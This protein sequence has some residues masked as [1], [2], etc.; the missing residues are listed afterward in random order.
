MWPRTCAWKTRF[1]SPSRSSSVSM[2]RLFSIARTMSAICAFLALLLHNVELLV[3]L[4][5]LRRRRRDRDELRVLRFSSEG[6]WRFRVFSSHS[7]QYPELPTRYLGA[8]QF[9]VRHCRRRRAFSKGPSKECVKSNRGCPVELRVKR[10]LTF[11]DLCLALA[12]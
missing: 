7:L 12:L 8:S 1:S 2:S 10:V 5:K 3:A 6:A 4:P 11:V 9:G